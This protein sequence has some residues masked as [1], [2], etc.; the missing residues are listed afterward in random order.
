MHLFYLN[1]QGDGGGT[2]KL[3]KSPLDVV[4]WS[5]YNHMEFHEESFAI[6]PVFKTMLGFS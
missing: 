2:V 6:S 3:L 1:K 5:S 4:D